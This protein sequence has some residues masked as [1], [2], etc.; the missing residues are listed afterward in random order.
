[1]SAF[2]FVLHELRLDLRRGGIVRGAPIVI[3]AITLFVLGL[4]LVV[5]VNLRKG[6]SAAQDKV[7]IVVFASSDAPE[8]VEALRTKFEAIRGVREARFVSRAEALERFRQ[9]LGEQEDLLDAVNT[10]PLPPSYEIA[11]YDDF[12]SE[13]ELS[14]IAAQ[15]G[16][17]EGVESVRYGSDW[18][19]R[20]QRLI[21]FSVLINLFL[22]I[23]LGASTIVSV[24]NTLRLALQERRDS[25]EVMRLVGAS[26]SMI[27]TPVFLQGGILGAIGAGI[28]AASLFGCYAL[29]AG[30]VP[31]LAFMGPRL[32]GAFIV[33]GGALGGIGS[34]L[35]LGRI[36]R[37][38]V[39]A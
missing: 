5:T 15:V 17:I 8:A 27:S 34:L 23:L 12:K 30:R 24:A 7:E 13:T 21:I 11:I 38:P 1:M 20:L 2:N 4:F 36:L 25:I 37:Q 18:V 33:T 6:I 14:V 10:N 22:G 39:R 28:A 31:E 3:V 29:L 35:A 26:S 32:L 19:G 9:D 16:L